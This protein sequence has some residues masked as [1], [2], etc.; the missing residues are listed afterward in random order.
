MSKVTQLFVGVWLRGPLSGV[1]LSQ[2]LSCSKGGSSGCAADAT[3]VPELH[4]AG[5]GV[6]FP[7][8]L[9]LLIPSVR[10]PGLGQ[11]CR[12]LGAC[13]HKP[14]PPFLIPWHQGPGWVI[15]AACT[16]Q[17]GVT[18]AEV[19]GLGEESNRNIQRAGRPMDLRVGEL[20]IH[21]FK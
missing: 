3:V 2:R 13:I 4:T 10:V 19:R 16:Q 11:L 8:Y 17:G 5:F 15:R 7:G 14:W 21:S 1:Q 18:G 9:L 12:L 6:H 20:I